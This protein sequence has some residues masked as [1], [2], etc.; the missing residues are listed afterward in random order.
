MIARVETSFISSWTISASLISA[1]FPKLTNLLKPIPSFFA[2]SNTAV[3][4]APLWDMKA[5]FPLSGRWGAKEA[6]RGVAVSI[7][8]KQLGPR[9]RILCFLQR[10]IT[11]CSI[12]VPSTPHS[13]NPAEIMM[14]LLIP[15]SPI[16]STIVGTIRA[17]TATTPRSISPSTSRTLG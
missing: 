7:I 6:F 4:N 11:A 17:G 14:R 16:S 5:V 8:P 3:P 15:F 2:Q 10:D 13:L 1:L 12:F 9:T